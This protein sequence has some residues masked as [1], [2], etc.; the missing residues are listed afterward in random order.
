MSDEK[1]EKTACELIAERIYAG[2]FDCLTNE[3]R[4]TALDP[5]TGREVVNA[6]RSLHSKQK[7][8]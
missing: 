8:C 1:F 5:A 2:N 7:N 3:E 4:F 6:L